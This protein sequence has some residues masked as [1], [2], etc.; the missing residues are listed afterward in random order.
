MKP[1]PLSKVH[2]EAAIAVALKVAKFR[3]PR[4]MTPTDS[5]EICAKA[6]RAVME[7]FERCSWEVVNAGEY[8]GF[9]TG[10]TF[11]SVRREPSET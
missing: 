9:T 3:A 6:A 10:D 1:E 2:V 4:R 8:P 11:P 5:D 7:H